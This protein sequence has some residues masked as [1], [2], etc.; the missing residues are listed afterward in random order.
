M[1]FKQAYL[2]KIRKMGILAKESEMPSRK[3][4]NQ[5]EMSIKKSGRR[6]FEPVSSL[7]VHKQYQKS[8]KETASENPEKEIEEEFKGI[9]FDPEKYYQKENELMN[10]LLENYDKSEQDRPQIRKYLRLLDKRMR[11]S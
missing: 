11:T 7:K 5:E 8:K 10:K 3:A 4:S 6:G 9:P 1:D 2:D